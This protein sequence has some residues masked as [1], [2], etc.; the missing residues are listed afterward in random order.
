MKHISLIFVWLCFVSHAIAA[1]PAELKKWVEQGNA[2]YQQEKYEDAIDAYQKALHSDYQSA[3][4]YFNLGNAYYKLR[5]IAPAIYNYEKALQLS[6]NDAEIK[7]N[8]KY[9]QQMTI[10]DIK[11]VPKVGFRE[12]I[13]NFVSILS[14]NAWAWVSVVSF[15]AMLAFFIGYYFGHSSTQKRAFFSLFFVCFGVGAISFFAGFKNKAL[16]KQNVYAIVFADAAEV[17]S[18]PKK[19]ADEAFVLHEGTK[20]KVLES[21]ETW[22]KIMIADG[23]RGWVLDKDIK[24]LK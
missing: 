24:K 2:F 22:T 9:A 17:L 20:V 10:D 6:P 8:L 19:N 3:A 7:T 5:D 13:Q 15:F 18:E 12:M 14:Y 16:S 11:V 21:N 23:K 1:T 4:V